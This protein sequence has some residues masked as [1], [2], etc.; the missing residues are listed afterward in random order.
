[1]P[2]SSRI[3]SVVTI[4]AADPDGLQANQGFNVEVG[5]DGGQPATV[6][7]FGL[8]DVDDRTQ[9]VDPSDVSGNISV[10]LD[11][12]Y[13]DETVTNVDLMLGEEVI[14]CR[15]AS[16]DA[17]SPVGLADSGGSVEIECFFDTDQVA[18][19]CTGMQMEPRFA[20]G[21]YQLGAQITTSDG[22]VRQALA[23][24][25]I[26]LNNSN[27]VMLSHSPGSMST[28]VSGVTFHGGP[29]GEDEGNVNAF[30]AC[31]VAFNG[32][33]V[34]EISL[35]AMVTGPGATAIEDEDAPPALAF[36]RRGAASQYGVALADKEAPFTWTAN[37][38]INGA[39][40]NTAGENEHWLI[41]SGDI[42]DDGGLLVTGEFR[43]DE[44]AKLGPRYFDFKAP[45]FATAADERG[46][47]LHLGGARFV[48]VENKY[49]SAG[50]FSL[51]GL[52]DA[53]VGG[54]SATIAVGDCSLAANSDGDRR[55]A[56]VAAEG[57]ADVSGIGDLP[58]DDPNNDFSDDDGVNCYLAEATGVRDGFMNAASP[59]AGDSTIQTAAAFGVDKGDP[60]LSDLEP[61]ESGLVLRS[62]AEIS[63]DVEDPELA[64]G[65][66]GSDISEV[67][68]WTGPRY[69]HP[70][71]GVSGTASV[72]DGIVTISTDGMGRRDGRRNVTVEVRDHATPAN[73]A[74]ASFSFVRD[75]E[76]PTYTL[77]KTQG[78]IDPQSATAVTVSI[79]GTI[80]DANVIRSAELELRRVNAGQTCAKA[81]T[82]PRREGTNARVSRNKI[83]LENDTNSITFEESFTIRAPSGKGTGPEDLCFYLDSED[84]AVTPSG[85][86]DGNP[87]KSVLNE[88]AVSWRDDPADPPGPTFEFMN[89]D[90][91]AIDMPLEVMEGAS[92]EYAVKLANVATAPT[93]AAPL[94]VTITASAGAT[95]DRPTLSFNGT[96]DT[97]VVT[98]TATQDRD[99]T[100]ED[101]I[102]LTHSATGYDDGTLTVKSLDDDVTL[103]VRESS[104]TEGDDDA[105][106]FYVVATLTT[107]RAAGTDV[108]VAWEFGGGTAA[109]GDYSSIG[110]ADIVIPGG[111]MSDSVEVTLTGTDDANIEGDETVYAQGTVGGDAPFVIPDE[112]T[113]M[114]DD[115]NV[116]LMVS[117]GS[118]N[119]GDDAT[120]LK[121]SATSEVAMPA[122]FDVVV[123][124][125]AGAGYRL[126][127]GD[128]AV[129]VTLTIDTG[130]KESINPQTVSLDP[131]EDEDTND[132]TIEI[133]GPD[134]GQQIGGAGKTYSVKSAM[135]TIVD[136]DDS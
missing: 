93:A 132:V 49:Y 136:N 54:A 97:L 121:I 17:A 33:T 86:N 55:T 28:V 129:T 29:A 15:G 117:P 73:T 106:A 57:L 91:S 94:A 27:Y 84:I 104:I 131:L 72:V 61:D 21:D 23:S 100:S 78:D 37:P 111:E 135:V 76:G 109:A 1:M 128:D 79:G 22:S 56:F 63:F 4:T 19:E 92:H 60:V 32:T 125:P 59:R 75:T 112:V 66:P 124:V 130:K 96:Q 134:G 30:H 105:E 67:R 11:V 6:T 77:S 98:V 110:V 99:V 118:V 64:T 14:S 41:N 113:I 123:T 39:V 10:L 45:T 18:G 83:D 101:D 65:E 69:E 107:A 13:N 35:M 90:E 115:P 53:G 88:F 40:E 38:A 16:S 114:D 5:Q 42:K 122:P 87:S 82:L 3:S 48:S 9:A 46:I 80:S 43:G 20:N 52:A 102:T 47:R 85:R 62:G 50:N 127:G 81:D 24:Q 8:R 95:V 103:K 34:G 7:I 51:N 12:Q 89:T 71:L 31:P 44:E 26:T 133:A 74:R 119:E 126:N 120:T 58:E 70:T 116:T 25:T 68:W 108:T 36:F 2:N